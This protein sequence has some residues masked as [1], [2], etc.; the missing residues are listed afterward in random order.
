MELNSCVCRMKV[1]FNLNSQ[2]E[3]GENIELF[4]RNELLITD[5]EDIKISIFQ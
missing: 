5:Y 3:G 2:G 4:L 1:F